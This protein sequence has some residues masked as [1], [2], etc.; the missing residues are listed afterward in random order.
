MK[1]E[2][3]SLLLPEEPA[4]LLQAWPSDIRISQDL[5]K[6][7]MNQSIRQSAVICTVLNH[8]KRHLTRFTPSEKEIEPTGPKE[9]ACRAS[10]QEN[11]PCGKKPR[12]DLRLVHRHCV[13]PI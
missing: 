11:L 7:Y 9:E 10:G 8:I 6:F 1:L 5:V 4:D 3:G 13:D 12:A 2:P